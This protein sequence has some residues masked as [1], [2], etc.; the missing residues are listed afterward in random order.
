MLFFVLYDGVGCPP[1]REVLHRFPRTPAIAEQGK[2][3]KG[4]GARF[5]GACQRRLQSPCFLA[6]NFVLNRHMKRRR[7]LIL[8]GEHAM[9][10]VRDHVAQ[11]KH[12]GARQFDSGTAA[13]RH[14]AIDLSHHGRQLHRL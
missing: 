8:R 2:A 5:D 10:M 4:E 3:A 11:M 1:E 13:E 6:G 9:E 12:V 14:Q 7:V